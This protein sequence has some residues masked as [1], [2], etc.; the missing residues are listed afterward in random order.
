MNGRARG[1]HCSCSG[2]RGP[3][4]GNCTMPR[5]WFCRHDPFVGAGEVVVVESW[6]Q[7]G[8]SGVNIVQSWSRGLVVASRTGSVVRD[9]VIGVRISCR[10]LFVA[11]AAAAV[12]VAVAVGPD[13]N[14]QTFVKRIN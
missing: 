8:S 4:E 11:A 6:V 10:S 1:S 14:Y 9:V 7:V 13:C 2:A 3:V 12:A 5:C